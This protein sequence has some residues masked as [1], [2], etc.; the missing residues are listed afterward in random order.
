[1]KMLYKIIVVFP[2]LTLINTGYSQPTSFDNTILSNHTVIDINCIREKYGIPIFYSHIESVNGLI[3]ASSSVT[4]DYAFKE[5]GYIIRNMVNNCNIIIDAL[6]KNNCY[7]TIISHNNNIT[8]LPEYS[9]L[10]PAQY[11]NWRIRGVSLPKGNK[12]FCC[13][14][15]NLLCYKGDPYWNENVL[16]HEFAHAIH[17]IAM[18]EIDPNFDSNLE[19]VYNKAIQKGLWNGTYSATDKE[20]YFAEGVQY[21]FM[22]NGY[23]DGIHTN[24][25]NRNDLTRYD[26]DLAILIYNI[27]GDNP[28]NYTRPHQ[29]LK[30]ENKH[31]EGYDRDKAPK[32]ILNKHIPDAISDPHH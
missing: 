8:D 27:F 29:R 26:P 25:A 21:W 10:K 30:S 19:K 4:S 14:E 28:W 20:E 1:M 12:M 9:D 18:P 11:W 23:S 24:I 5:T 13:G 15:E 31:L 6:N 2:I 17:L 7:L 16:I 32:Y 22:A 3:V